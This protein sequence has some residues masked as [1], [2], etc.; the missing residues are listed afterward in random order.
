M[1]I[2]SRVNDNYFIKSLKKGFNTYVAFEEF[3]L[4]KYR[5][6]LSILTG[7]DGDL[8]FALLVFKDRLR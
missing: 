3:E 1:K 4:L 2:C 6:T 5:A 8:L 7:R